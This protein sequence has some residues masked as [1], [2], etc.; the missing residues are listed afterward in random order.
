MVNGMKKNLSTVTHYVAFGFDK[1]EYEGFVSYE[2]DMAKASPDKPAAKVDAEDWHRQGPSQGPEREIRC[3]EGSPVN[4][5]GAQ[6]R[7]LS[8]RAL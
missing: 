5:Y 3:V 7:L 1:P 6:S 8:Y 4:I 2:E